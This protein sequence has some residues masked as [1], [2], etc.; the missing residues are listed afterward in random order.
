MLF[1]CITLQQKHE[2]KTSFIQCFFVTKF[3][4]E[5]AAAML[6]VA[7]EMTLFFQHRETPFFQKK[8]FSLFFS[9]PITR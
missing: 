2:A 1:I 4:D 5:T 9:P 6:E 7:A 3:R 8:H